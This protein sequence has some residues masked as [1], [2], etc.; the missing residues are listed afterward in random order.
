MDGTT[1]LRELNQLCAGDRKQL[2]TADRRRCRELLAAL[3]EW[4]QGGGFAPH[5]NLY[6][7]GTKAYVRRYGWR[8]S[9]PERFR[10]V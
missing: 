10:P 3:H 5:W 2:P 6:A 9:M 8:P 7:E 4:L 1:L